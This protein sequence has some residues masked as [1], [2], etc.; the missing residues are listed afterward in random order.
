[1]VVGITESE[2]LRRAYESYFS[3]H[4]HNRGIESLA[5][6]EL[7]DHESEMNIGQDKNSFRTIV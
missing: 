1:M 6:Y 4:I 7:I 3:D 2:Q 5:S